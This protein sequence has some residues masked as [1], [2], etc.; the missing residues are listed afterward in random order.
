MNPA[1]CRIFC[2]RLHFSP[3]YSIWKKRPLKMAAPKKN[4]YTQL[5]K[6]NRVGKPVSYSP[7]S[8]W[9]KAVEYFS[10]VENNPLYERKAFGTGLVADLPKLRAM[11]ICGF[12]IFAGI[13]RQTF[14]NY[15]D[16]AEYFGITTRIRDIIYDQKFTGAA[17][18]LLESN[19]IARELGL[20]DKKDVTT[21]GQNVTASPLNDLPTEALLEIEQIAKKYG[22]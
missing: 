6:K 18:G 20:V 4:T 1:F 19:I 5:A 11:S 14:A 7:E 21:N 22:K 16:K 13:D 9:K 3:A 15:E 2:S 10:W 12:C 17:A 8:L